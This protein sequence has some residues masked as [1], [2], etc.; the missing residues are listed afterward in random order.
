MGKLIEDP[1]I[2]GSSHE[3]YLT[4]K[5]F[6]DFV[7]SKKLNTREIH[8]KDLGL[9]PLA[10]D[11]ENLLRKKLQDK[12][13]GLELSVPDLLQKSHIPVFYSSTGSQS[14]YIPEPGLAV[15]RYFG[16]MWDDEIIT[17]K[18]SDNA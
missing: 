18:N 17:L 12:N 16:Q 14:V 7:Q 3:W 8:L 2:F 10:E 4:G 13:T 11:D 6:N 1:E 15:C 5:S 9:F